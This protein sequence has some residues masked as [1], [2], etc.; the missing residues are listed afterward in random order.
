MK[1]AQDYVQRK[2]NI[3]PVN[4]SDDNLGDRRI[5]TDCSK[6]D[7]ETYNISSDEDC[8]TTNI[9]DQLDVS[10]STR[11]DVHSDR[12]CL[13]NHLV[14]S[15]QVPHAY[16]IVNSIIQSIKILNIISI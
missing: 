6:Y 11:H 10:T 9:S 12:D 13:V 16:I 1:A 8:S 15:A 2:R 4:Y 7:I 5:S 3:M 14:T